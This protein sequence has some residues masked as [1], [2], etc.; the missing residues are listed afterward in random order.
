MKITVNEFAQSPSPLPVIVHSI[1]MVGY[2][3]TV[4]IDE[5][6]CLLVGPNARPLRYQS[7]MQMREKLNTLPTRS[8]VLSHQSAY[9]EMINLPV[10]KGNNTLNV[11]LSSELYP[12]PTRTTPP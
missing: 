11:P 6:E 10:N 8:V 9:D 2:Q 12:A 1:D 7:L 3:A 4:I 5:K